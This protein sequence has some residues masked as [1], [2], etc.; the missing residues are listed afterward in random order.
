MLH[1][2]ERKTGNQHEIIFGKR[3]RLR[4]VL[5][6]VS[7]PA[8]GHLLHL[9]RFL[10]RSSQLRFAHVNSWFRWILRANS[11]EW[12][13]RKGKKISADRAGLGKLRVHAVSAHLLGVT[14]NGPA[15]RMMKIKC[16]SSLQIRLVKAR[17]GHAGVHGNEQRVE[18]FAAVVLVFIASDG[19]AGRASVAGEC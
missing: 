3:K 2:A 14:D 19:F 15:G 16:E 7:D 17:K 10:L 12:P 13:G 11:S 9:R 5:C 1:A 18:I 4:K 6:E 8:R